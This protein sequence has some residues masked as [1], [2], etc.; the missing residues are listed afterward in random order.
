[1]LVEVK[2]YHQKNA[3]NEY[4]M[5]SDYLHYRYADLVNIVLRI[6]IYWSKWCIWTLVSPDDFNRNG[7]KAIISLS[8]ALKRNQM[9]TLGDVMIG[10]IPPLSIHIYPDKQNP[11]NILENDKAEF[12]ISKVEML[13]KNKPIT[14]ESE[15]RI[16]F[17]LMRFGN[18]AE[19]TM[20]ITAPNSEKEIEYIEFSYFP[21]EYDNE[22]VF[23]MIDP[24]ST[25]ISRQ[26][27]QLTAPDGKVE[28]L[29]PDIAPGMLGFV[30]PENYKGMVLPL[31]RFH[32]VPNYE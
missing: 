11:H 16:E 23:C 20:I 32:I 1:M 21:Q 28:R 3:F 22:Q 2:N 4:R 27:G 31:W 5:N 9:S 6:A 24:L 15:Q 10:T 14:V 26:Y 17:A 19:S 7:K 29:T 12:T 18:W 25:I 13:C 8:T 30:I